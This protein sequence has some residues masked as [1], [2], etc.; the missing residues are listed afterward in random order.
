MDGLRVPVVE[1]WQT[2]PAASA[3]VERRNDRSAGQC[4]LSIGV[5]E[6]LAR[7]SIRWGGSAA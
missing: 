6:G 2:Q 4:R 3:N 1:A 5:L 7:C